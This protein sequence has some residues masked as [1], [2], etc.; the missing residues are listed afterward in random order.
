MRFVDTGVRGTL[1]AHCLSKPIDFMQARENKL[2]IGRQPIFRHSERWKRF[3]IELCEPNPEDHGRGRP[4]SGDLVQNLSDDL[5]PTRYVNNHKGR[6][7]PYKNRACSG[8]LTAILSSTLTEVAC[9]VRTTAS[10]GSEPHIGSRL[11]SVLFGWR[12]VLPNAAILM[13][14]APCSGDGLMTKSCED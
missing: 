14:N 9:T 11:S 1:S 10:F 5:F 8:V 7:F 6:L 3:S 12:P 2:V 4:V 13:R